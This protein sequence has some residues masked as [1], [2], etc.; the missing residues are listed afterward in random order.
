M[1]VNVLGPRKTRAVARVTGLPVIR[2]MVWSHDESGRMAY[3]TTAD[4][5]HGYFDRRTGEWEL[6]PDAHHVSYCQTLF[7]AST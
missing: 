5:Q 6:D 1:G 3:F 7:P 2:A 4:H